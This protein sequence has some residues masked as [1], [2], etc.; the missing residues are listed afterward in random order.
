MLASSCLETLSARPS[1]PASA[2][3]DARLRCR[4]P[5]PLPAPHP[6]SSPAPRLLLCSPSASSPA[7]F[8]PA[9]AA[10]A[11]AAPVLLSDALPHFRPSSADAPVPPLTAPTPS[12]ADA[13][14][15]PF[16]LA[17]CGRRRCL[18]AA[19]RLTACRR[20]R[21]AARRG[22]VPPR[23]PAQVPSGDDA[24][25]AADRRLQT[26]RMERTGLCGPAPSGPAQTQTEGQTD[27]FL[28]AGLDRQLEV[29]A[30]SVQGEGG[31]R[32]RR[33]EV[34]PRGGTRCRHE[35]ARGRGGT[36]CATRRL[37]LKS[38]SVLT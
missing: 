27:A 36:R 32:S 2:S 5:V 19:Q 20:R 22:A 34:S 16:P 3:P 6:A 10:F 1:P 24:R 13:P 23:P 30:K 29:E 7:G 17:V 33:H 26:V 37:P 18:G 12:L 11:A 28:A 9:F 35:A 8:V 25:G 38:G 15:L 31:T 14:P 4:P 21:G